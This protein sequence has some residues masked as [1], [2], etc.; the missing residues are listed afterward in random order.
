VQRG[1]EVVRDDAGIAVRAEPRVRC[2]QDAGLVLVEAA[3]AQLV[4]E[5]I[6]AVDEQGVGK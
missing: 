2:E 4:A 1:C 5:D 6:V 3:R